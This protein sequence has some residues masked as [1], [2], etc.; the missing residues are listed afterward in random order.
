MLG[1]SLP[2]FRRLLDKVCLQQ[3]IIIRSLGS[4]QHFLQTF[5]DRVQNSL[6]H[7][8][9]QIR[10]RGSAAGL[11]FEFDHIFATLIQLGWWLSEWL[12]V[13]LGLL[14]ADHRCRALGPADG[15]FRGLLSCIVA[16][17][18]TIYGLHVW[19]DE[20]VAAVLMMLALCGCGRVGW[21]GRVEKWKEDVAGVRKLKLLVCDLVIC[22]T[23]NVDLVPWH[24]D[25]LV[26]SIE[27]LGLIGTLH[28]G[29]V[30]EVK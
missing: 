2:T 20:D 30:I 24:I 12:G 14:V 9:R 25:V 27:D 17:F 3:R 4:G 29:L 16:F 10:Y 13:D 19:S 8:C 5:P 23:L 21:D 18:L 22:R 7:I 26:V 6:V 11:L 15:Q 28:Q 1:T